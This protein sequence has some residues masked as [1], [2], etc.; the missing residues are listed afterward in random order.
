MEPRHSGQS[1][2]DLQSGT[3]L[4]KKVPAEHVSP[5]EELPEAKPSKEANLWRNIL[6]TVV[7]KDHNLSLGI[8][9]EDQQFHTNYVFLWDDYTSLVV[10]PESKW[11]KVKVIIPD[12]VKHNG[13]TKLPGDAYAV[14][15]VPN[16]WP[17]SLQP[18]RP[19]HVE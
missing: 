13:L 4:L 11:D 18:N 15:T 1:H 10:F 19:F 7:P 8:L 16:T 3:N 14:H 5:E 6:Y 2:G 9:P 12:S 17:M